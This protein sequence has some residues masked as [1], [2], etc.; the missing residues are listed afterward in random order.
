[1]YKYDALSLSRIL[2][3]PFSSFISHISVWLHISYP[4]SLSLYLS[5]TNS[6]LLSPSHL[7]SSPLI[8]THLTLYSPNPSLYSTISPFPPTHSSF[9]NLSSPIP[10]FPPSHISLYSSPPTLPSHLPSL[11]ILTPSLSRL[12]RS[13]L[14]TGKLFVNQL[15]YFTV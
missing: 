12:Y 14:D 1:M 7:H 10:P 6:L 13:T 4:I 15:F 2:A 5:L 9:L 3:F 11:P 8:Y